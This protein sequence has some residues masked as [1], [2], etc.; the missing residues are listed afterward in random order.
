MPKKIKLHAFDGEWHNGF[1]EELETF[2]ADVRRYRIV[3]D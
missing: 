3:G 1:D 2:P